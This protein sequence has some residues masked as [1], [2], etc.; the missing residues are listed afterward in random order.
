MPVGVLRTLK[1]TGLAWSYPILNTF[2]AEP[3]A[4]GG[5]AKTTCGQYPRPSKTAK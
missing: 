2:P 4:E 1:N 5:C 3:S